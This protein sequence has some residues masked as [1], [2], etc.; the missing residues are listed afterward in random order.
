MFVSNI[1]YIFFYLIDHFKTLRTCVCLI[2]FSSFSV[3]TIYASIQSIHFYNGY[4]V[5]VYDTRFSNS[6]NMK[7]SFEKFHPL[8]FVLRIRFRQMIKE[9]FIQLIFYLQVIM[10]IHLRSVVG[11]A[12]L[13][14]LIIILS[15]Q[16]Q[17]LQEKSEIRSLSYIFIYIRIFKDNF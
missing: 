11:V 8:V 1:T 5:D 9:L 10:R 6:L 13:L 3:Y 12:F 17:H 15:Y 2:F 7:D 16:A 14:V 4:S